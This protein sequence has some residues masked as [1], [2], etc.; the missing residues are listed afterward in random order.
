MD[1]GFEI[2]GHTADVGIRAWGPSPE[3][4]FEQAGWGLA[5]ILGAVATGPGRPHPIEADGTDVGALVV[6]FLDE[7]L[8]LHETEEAAFAAI[9]VDR[10]EDTAAVGE[11]ELAP[12][13]GEPDGTAVK[14]ATYHQ[15]RVH[16]EQ[17]GRTEITVYLDV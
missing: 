1:A 15:L 11:V 7:L 6:A 3:R 14:A 16:T 17:D 8:F 9:R 4:A 13:E 10:V 2:L 12:L 5:E